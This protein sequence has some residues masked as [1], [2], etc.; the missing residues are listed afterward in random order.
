M[1]AIKPVVLASFLISFGCVIGAKANDAPHK[2]REEAVSFY[3]DTDKTQI[4]TGKVRFYGKL[5]KK[6]KYPLGLVFGG[7]ESAATVLDLLNPKV[8][9][10]LASF[11]YPYRVPH[12]VTV[13]QA[14]TLAPQARRSVRATREGIVPFTERLLTDDRI[15]SKK[16]FLLGASFGV[17]FVLSVA[18]SPLFQAVIILYG[19]ADY[20]KAIAYQ[21]QKRWKKG[22]GFLS[23]PAAWFSARAISLYLQF[24]DLPSHI[25]RWDK[26]KKVF[27]I[28]GK[29]D[30]FI[31]KSVTDSLKDKIVSSDS[32]FTYVELEGNH[33]MPGANKQIDGLTSRVTDWLRAQSLLAQ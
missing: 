9:V 5:N 20:E 30:E 22:I 26:D 31:P 19:F 11:D 12:K 28:S 25:R 29:A 3:L 2:F 21:L 18:E 27:M 4:H 13:L 7:F 1:V 16:V 24:P 6:Q 8:P 17:P 23:T 32:Q 33:L 10:A 15:D 14:V